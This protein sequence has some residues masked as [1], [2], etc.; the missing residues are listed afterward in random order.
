MTI[1]LVVD[2]ENSVTHLDNRRIDN[3][4]N[5]KNNDLISS[6]ILNVHTGKDDKG[7]M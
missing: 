5:N 1:R 6:G 3:R 4:P 7:T 2:V